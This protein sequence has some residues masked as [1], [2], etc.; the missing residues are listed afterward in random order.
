VQ[1]EYASFEISEQAAGKQ[2]PVHHVTLHRIK[3]SPFKNRGWRINFNILMVATA[4]I[5]Y[6]QVIPF[7]D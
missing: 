1:P 4:A 7:C 5:S 3:N 6:K 2:G